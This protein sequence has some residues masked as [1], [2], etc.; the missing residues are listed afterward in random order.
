MTVALVMLAGVFGLVIGSVLN[1]VLWR[2]PRGES[3]VSPPS[4]C[5]AC[6]ARLGPPDLIPVMSWL[7]LRGRCRHCGTEISARYPSI[8]LAVGI[9]FALVAWLVVR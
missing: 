9:A 1:V 5:T 8:E 7:V 3:V 2:V 4:H 6:D